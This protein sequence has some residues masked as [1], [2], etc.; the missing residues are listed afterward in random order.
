MDKN[1]KKKIL[2]IIKYTV[3]TLIILV[4]LFGLYNLIYSFNNNYRDYEFKLSSNAISIPLG[5]SSDIPIVSVDDENVD[6]DDYIYTATDNAI[7]SVTEDGKII[8]N[9]IGSTVVVVKAKK[10]NQ[11]ELLNVSVVLKGDILT[12][13]DINLIDTE[14]NLKVGEKHTIN[15][16]I[17]PTGALTDNIKW[18]SSNTSVAVVDNGIITGKKVGN[19]VISVKEGN[20]SK[21]IQVKVSK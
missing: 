10:S 14:V 5:Q 4:L 9:K 19:C 1:K 8:G 21:Q 17:I 13:Q 12:I 6:L 16:E 2:N 15:Y 3:S 7:V 18:S 11:K 20:I